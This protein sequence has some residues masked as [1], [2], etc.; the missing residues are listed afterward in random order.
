MNADELR[1]AI[2]DAHK[3][4]DHARIAK[5]QAQVRALPLAERN[6]VTGPLDQV[7]RVRGVPNGEQRAP[8][9][10]DGEL[11][12][13]YSVAGGFR[14]MTIDEGLEL[15]AAIRRA[16]LRGDA[17]SS[18]ILWRLTERLQPAAGAAPAMWSVGAVITD[19][20]LEEL[21]PAATAPVRR[22][23]PIAEADLRITWRDHPQLMTI[24]S[25]AL[26]RLRGEARAAGDGRETGGWVFAPIDGPATELVVVCGDGPNAERHEGSLRKDAEALVDF[27]Y[28]LERTY[29]G[30]VLVG[31]WHTHPRRSQV[32]STTDLRSMVALLEDLE[33]R[34]AHPSPA[35]IEVIVT[36]GSSFEYGL[37]LHPY[38]ARRDPIS[39]RVIFENARIQEVH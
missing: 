25:A 31:G 7:D 29:P 9:V 33:E 17:A 14:A 28:G 8:S 27:E 37:E 21:A 15:R 12:I 36:S 3:T 23:A 24:H 19:A 6:R 34:G 30:L 11:A 22:S 10:A 38:V 2:L 1:A 5:L 20:D 35:A 16:H 4:G 26:S 32:P 18:E 13:T 39:R